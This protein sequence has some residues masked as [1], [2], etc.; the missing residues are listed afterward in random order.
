MGLAKTDEAPF[1]RLPIQIPDMKLNSRVFDVALGALLTVFFLSQFSFKGSSPS[2]GQKTS[3][4]Q[5]WEAPVLPQALSFAG[6]KV[7]LERWDVRERMDREVLVNYYNQGTIL[8]LLKLANRNFPIISERLKAN[9]VPDDFKYLCIAESNMQPLALSRVGAVGYW[10]FM[11]GTAPGFGLEV[12]DQVDQ[13]QHLEKSTD[14]ACRY[15][16]QA[17]G[18]FG[19]WTAAAASYNCGQGGYNGQA[20]FQRTKY[21]YDLQLPEET[22]RYIYRILTFKY[23]LE[24]A[25][26]MGYHLADDEKYGPVP[27]REV[28]VSSS[29]PNLADYALAQGT[30]Y[31][32][33]RLLNPWVK[34]R[35]LSVAPGK[36][37]VLKLPARDKEVADR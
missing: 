5:R 36:T 24:N 31:Q 8:Y 7:P 29:I 30:T 16:K 35:A 21:Y 25:E 33:L 10:Q 14:A 19:N 15:L 1:L 13:R 28:T 23:L 27:V 12:S 20:T 37:Y 17:Y 4:N 11:N 26:R 18:K 2:N 34:G 3:M 32:M 9:G 22:N 6:E